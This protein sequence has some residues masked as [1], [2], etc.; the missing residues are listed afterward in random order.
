MHHSLE[1]GPNEDTTYLV[2]LVE[3]A[4]EGQGIERN[5]K[6]PGVNFAARMVSLEGPRR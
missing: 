5:I 4:Q 1:N 2:N 3:L 6:K